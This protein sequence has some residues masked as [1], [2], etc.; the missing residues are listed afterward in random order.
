V[1]MCTFMQKVNEHW[2][3]FRFCARAARAN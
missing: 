3:T 2:H 1:I